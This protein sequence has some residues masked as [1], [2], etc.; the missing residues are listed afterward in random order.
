MA[1]Y[2]Y[3]YGEN[4]LQHSVEVGIISGMLA[5]Q[6]NINI[7]NSKMAGFLHDIGSTQTIKY[8]PAPGWGGG[9]R[10]ISLVYAKL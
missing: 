5:S 8:L 3:S 1:Q 7:Q 2:R 9:G 4:V 6:L 10:C